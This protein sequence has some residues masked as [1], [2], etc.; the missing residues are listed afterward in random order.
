MCGVKEVINAAR[1]HMVHHDL[2]D[3][4]CLL[5]WVYYNDVMARFSLRHWVGKGPEILSTPPSIPSEVSM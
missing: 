4:A 5:D 1:L 3:I 2:D